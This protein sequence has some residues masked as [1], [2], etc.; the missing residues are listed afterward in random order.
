MFTNAT[1]DA[2]GEYLIVVDKYYF[3]DIF[4]KNTT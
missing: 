4:K 1:F 3:W 2:D